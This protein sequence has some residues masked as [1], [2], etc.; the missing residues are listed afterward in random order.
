MTQKLD[1]AHHAVERYISRVNKWATR[2]QAMAAIREAWRGA[3]RLYRQ[4]GDR[5]LYEANGGAFK[6]SVAERPHGRIAILSVLPSGETEDTAD[7]AEL[8][9]PPSRPIVVDVA[10]SK[11]IPRKKLQ[12]PVNL[13]PIE[14]FRP[15]SSVEEATERRKSAM[16]RLD[17][18]ILQQHQLPP[19]HDLRRQLEVD[20]QHIQRELSNLKQWIHDEHTAAADKLQKGDLHAAWRLLLDC[21]QYVPDR[22]VKAID[23]EV[24]RRWDP[25]RPDAEDEID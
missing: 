15:P 24:P 23:D 1:I 13:R 4:S 8:V 18:V 19:K 12:E 6:L 10:P 2:E 20:R 16:A 9:Q 7:E 25:N 14:E 21:R 3:R 11:W 22:L 5:V 17:A